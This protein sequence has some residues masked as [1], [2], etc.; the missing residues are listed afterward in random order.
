MPDRRVLLV[1]L[2]LFFGTAA[3]YAP[4][5]EYDFVRFD[6]PRIVSQNPYIEGGLDLETMRW[7]FTSAYKSNWHPLTWISHAIDIELFGLWAGGHHAVNVLF[8]ALN[9]VLLFGLLFDT[10]GKLWRSAFVAALFALHPLRVESVAWISERKDVLS[11]FFGLISIWCYLRSTRPGGTAWQWAC[12]ATL[13]LGMMAKSMLM[14]LPFLF[15]LLDYWP[16]RRLAAP[17][18]LPF[19]RL[20]QEKAALFVVAFTAIAMTAMAQR[21]GGALRA[22]A[23]VALPQRIANAVVAYATYLVNLIWPA[24]LAVHYPHPYMPIAG[25]TPL[26]GWQI[27]SSAVLLAAL[28]VGVVHARERRYLFVGWFWLVGMLAPAIGLL[29]A[30]TAALADRYT[31][32]PMVGLLIALTWALGDASLRLAPILRRGLWP[33]ALATIAACAIS[34]SQLLPTWRD[35]ISLFEHALAVSPRDT[36]MLLNLG[37]ELVERGRFEEGIARYRRLL[38]IAPGYRQAHLNLQTAL[39]RQ[40]AAQRS[41]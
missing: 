4:V 15:L 14:T 9:A 8:H 7:A 39:E 6:D 37:N 23:L 12:L 27:A 1:C 16:L 41:R 17:G 34:T 5:L 31:Y 20:V 33:L 11:S 18:G 30:G 21:A 35:S 28:S 29:Q 19:R 40:R 2:G 10:T 38:E 13:V 3:L 26:P 25:G 36:A 32:L 24:E 22:S